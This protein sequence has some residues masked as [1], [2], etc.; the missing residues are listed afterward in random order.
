MAVVSQHWSPNSQQH[1]KTVQLRPQNT[2]Q[3]PKTIQQWAVVDQRKAEI[4]NEHSETQHIVWYIATQ[5]RKPVPTSRGAK[6]WNQEAGIAT[7]K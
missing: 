2:K 4:R 7:I 3:Y 6:R 1:T 5:N